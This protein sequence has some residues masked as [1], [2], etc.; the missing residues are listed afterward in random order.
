MKKGK[1]MDKL[2]AKLK[3]PHKTYTETVSKKTFSSIRD[4]KAPKYEN[5]EITTKI[6][7]PF[8]TYSDLILVHVEPGNRFGKLDKELQRDVLQPGWMPDDNG[9]FLLITSR[10]RETDRE[11]R[12]EIHID[13]DAEE[14]ENLS[15]IEDALK[16]ALKTV[17][18]RIKVIE[19]EDEE[20]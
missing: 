4:P 19:K 10:I 15:N 8:N 3:L 16:R 12:F 2:M 13:T 17:Q 6:Y 9:A 5:V 7:K 14:W 18:T 1:T 11:N 20:K